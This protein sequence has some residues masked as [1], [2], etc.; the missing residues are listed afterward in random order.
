MD[1]LAKKCVD[2]QKILL[3][4]DWEKFCY[5]RKSPNAKCTKWGYFPPSYL[6][7]FVRETKR[8][9]GDVPVIFTGQDIIHFY[10]G[11]I[12]A[13]KQMADVLTNAPLWFA[14][15]YSNFQLLGAKGQLI[16][17]EKLRTGY[18]FPQKDKLMPWNDWVFWQYVGEK[19]EQPTSKITTAIRDQDADLSFYNGTRD[20]F[21][22]FFNLHAWTRKRTAANLLT[23]P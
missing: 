12:A 8:L 18:I 5:E 11:A 3:A 21:R 6:V 1:N 19:A 14:Q 15:Y 22:R 13:D 7:D 17:G 2:G 4:V 9:T 23:V 16:P 20:D 10:G